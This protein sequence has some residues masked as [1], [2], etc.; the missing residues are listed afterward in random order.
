ME[1]STLHPRVPHVV[2]FLLHFLGYLL[3]EVSQTILIWLHSEPHDWNSSARASQEF[4]G[5]FLAL[6]MLAVEVLDY[7]NW[8]REAYHRRLTMTV[9]NDEDPPLYP[10]PGEGSLR[11]CSALFVQSYCDSLNSC[12]CFCL[13]SI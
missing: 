4:I 13:F 9:H 8:S 10:I 2:Q 12:F 3:L 6:G 1:T 11:V 5:V 7:S